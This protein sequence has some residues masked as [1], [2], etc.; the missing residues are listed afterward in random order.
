MLHPPPSALM[1]DLYQLNM[2]QAYLDQGMT[3]TAVF[4]FFSR[5]LPDDRCFYMAAGLETVLSDLEGLRFT[6]EELAWLRESGRFKD[7][8]LDYLADFRFTGDVHAMAEGTVFFPSEPM[9]RLTAPLP[10]AQ[11]LETRLINILHFQSVI[12]T[13]ASRMVLAADGRPLVDFGLRRAH[14]M[15]AGLFA[16]RSAYLAGFSGTATVTAGPMFDIPLFGTMAHS[17]IL[18][19]ESELQAFLHY[20]RSRPEGLV[21]LID[22]YDTEQ[23]ARTAVEAAQILAAEG[24]PLRAVRLDSGDRIAL[25][26]AVRDILDAGGQEATTILVSGGLDEQKIAAMVA[27]NAPIDG[28]GVGTSLVTSEDDPVFDCAYKLHAYAGQAKRKKS[29]GK[30]TWPGAK[31]VFRRYDPQG[32]MNGDIL[33]VAEDRQ[34][35]EALL[36]PAMVGGQRIAPAPSFTERRTRAAGQLAALPETL[37]ILEGNAFYPVAIAPAL[38]ALTA[39]VD[40]QKH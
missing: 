15:E 35:G 3:D 30:A 39:K 2:M 16:A 34:D 10:M 29:A 20:A 5:A 21:L 31:Q 32:R 26:H 25:S 33:T 14:G 4:E 11:F 23:G 38:D 13:K 36:Q 28:F 40:A 18:A 22:T 12:A 7:N 9:L 27:A 19:H 1:T 8:L 17:F 6:E 37:K 24:I